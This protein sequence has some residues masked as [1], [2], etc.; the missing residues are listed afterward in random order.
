M[1]LGDGHALSATGAG[2]VSLELV[3]GGGKTRHCRLHDILYVPKL[4]YNLL[5]VSKVTEA[6]MK[7]KFH[8]TD[9]L[10]QNQEDK[11]IALGVKRGNLYYLN[12]RRPSDQIH[13]SDARLDAESKE[14]IWHRR[15][16]HLNER[17]L[18]T[19]ASQKLVDNLQYI[20]ENTF[21]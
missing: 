20:Q 5:S 11:L 6:G 13:V 16:G 10:I 17:S 7:V 15:F 1:M 14:F 18:H 8:S 3:L 4:V 2:D 9:C 19:L 21:L 12:C